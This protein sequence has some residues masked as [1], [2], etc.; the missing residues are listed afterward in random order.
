MAGADSGLQVQINKIQVGT[1]PRFTAIVAD[2]IVRADAG[3]IVAVTITGAAGAVID[4][5]DG[6]V[7]GGSSQ[8]LFHIPA[9]LG[10]G[11]YWVY[12]AFNKGL[13]IAI[14]TAV[15]DI[16]VITGGI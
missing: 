14:A 16:L 12:K 10:P 8:L 6:A 3:I 7:G 5:W 4:L 2:A 13:H 15:T 11:T 9:T 1:S